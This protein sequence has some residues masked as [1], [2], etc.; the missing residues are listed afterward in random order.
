MLIRFESILITVINHILEHVPFCLKREKDAH[1]NIISLRHVI[2]DQQNIKMPL[3][4][5]FEVTS[6][7]RE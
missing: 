1:S 6:E 5:Y 3:L 7:H 4:W 2:S